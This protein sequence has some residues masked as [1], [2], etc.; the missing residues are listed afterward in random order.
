M[1]GIYGVVYFDA[2][3]MPDRLVA[4]RMGNAIRHRGPDDQGT[5][6][7]P[8]I[9][10]GMQRLSI[11]D[12]SGGHQPIANEDETIWVVCNGEIYNFQGL[13]EGLIRDGHVF[14]TQSDTEVL[15]HLYEQQGL[16]FLRYLRGMFGLALWDSCNA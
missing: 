15:V 4:S 3:R 12:L 10:L 9:L 11:I 7:A 8:G 16:E 13:R 1:C 2:S 14:R 6:A 5:F